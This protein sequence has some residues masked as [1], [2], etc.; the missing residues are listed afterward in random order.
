MNH[1]LQPSSSLESSSSSSPDSTPLMKRSLQLKLAAAGAVLV[2]VLVAVYLRLSS[3]IESDTRPK[4]KDEAGVEKPLELARNILRKDVDLS[5]CRLALRQLNLHLNEAD[6]KQ[7]PALD[8]TR[9]EE[10]RR[11]LDLNEGE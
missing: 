11:Q 4:H 1:P 10:L 2:V 9:K 7:P 8:A 5:A 6:A 3:D